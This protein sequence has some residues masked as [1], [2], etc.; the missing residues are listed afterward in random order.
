M[1]LSKELGRW[2]KSTKQTQAQGA[3]A[4]GVSRRTFE[5]WIQGRHVPSTL[6]RSAISAKITAELA[7]L[8]DP[9]NSVK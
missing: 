8:K 5:D 3:A 4:L 1:D 9:K 2:L 7:A 6:A